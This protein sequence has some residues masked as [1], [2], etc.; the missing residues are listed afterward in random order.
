VLA[1]REQIAELPEVHELR[2]LR[3]AND[4]LCAPFDLL[5][6]VWKPVRQRVSRVIRPFD[7]LDQLALD[8]VH[9]SHMRLSRSNSLTVRGAR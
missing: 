8:E 1:G 9:Q 5:V 3:L 4:E 6:I 7:D 2:H